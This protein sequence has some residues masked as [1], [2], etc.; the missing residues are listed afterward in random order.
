MGQGLL[1]SCGA[2]WGGSIKRFTDWD[3]SPTLRLSLWTSIV[4]FSFLHCI[5]HVIAFAEKFS[6]LAFVS[7]QRFNHDLSPGFFEKPVCVCMM[8]IYNCNH[9]CQLSPWSLY[10]CLT[11]SK[12]Y[13]KRLPSDLDF[14]KLQWVNPNNH[15]RY[16]KKISGQETPN[17]VG[18]WGDNIW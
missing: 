3:S 18:E 5:L 4:I 6:G 15:T 8:W 7:L 17:S 14:R 10:C 13:D 2:E 11:G 1:S 9:A 12:Q 16:P